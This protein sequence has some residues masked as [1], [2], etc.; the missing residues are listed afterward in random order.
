MISKQEY[1]QRIRLTQA[2]LKQNNI[3]TLIVSEEED[4]YYLTG[5]T[6]KSLERL[7]ILVIKEQEVT[8][9]LPKMELAHLKSVD[10]VT[11]IKT[12]WEYPAQEPECWRDVLLEEIR[13]SYAIGIGSKAPYEIASF[14]ASVGL[15][16]MESHIVERLRWIKSEA[17]ISLIKRA[18]S[19]CDV[20]ISK[21][22]KNVYY[23]MTELEVFSVGR[24]IQQKVI[25]ETSFD[26]LASNILV[27]AWP[28]RISYQPHG[29]P[30]LSDVLV[31]GS[32]I[33]LAFLRVNGYSAELERTFFTSK[34]TR[35][36]EDAFAL[37]L[38]AR[39]RSYAMLKAGVIA[40]E[41]DFASKRFLSDKGLKANLMHRTGHGIG[42]GN[43]EG[44]FL[45]EGDKT[46]LQENMVVSIE[47]GIYIEGVGGFRH[48]DTVRITKDSYEILTSCADDIKSLTFTKSKPLQKLMGVVVKKM[49]GI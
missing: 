38:E 42:L 30:K 23:G 41:V 26:Y 6:Y 18:S 19:Y 47:P 9:I 39:R 5:L 37:M 28:S 45:A 14:I 10:N 12:Y 11:K 17:E 32:H 24:S 27:A 4:I 33:S 3:D 40:E 1:L 21:I 15:N 36:Q 8:F 2:A 13:K 22:N 16:V 44:P 25:K 7:F 29:I 43:H 49:Y 48:S 34:P 20:S 46:V 31:E 35:E